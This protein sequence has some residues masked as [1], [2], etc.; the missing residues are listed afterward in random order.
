MGFSDQIDF[1]KVPE[2]AEFYLDYRYLKQLLNI[3]D[4]LGYKK[5]LIKRLE[6]GGIEV[7]TFQKDKIMIIERTESS[8]LLDEEK[9]NPEIEIN[10]KGIDFKKKPL[11]EV[12]EMLKEKTVE[13]KVE[14]FIQMYV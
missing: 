4:V 3:F 8:F 14:Y 13:E 5:K 10:L 11:E 12:M 2:W 1:Y 7:E 6:S 9:N